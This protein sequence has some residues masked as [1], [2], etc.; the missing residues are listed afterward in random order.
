MN[1][2]IIRITTPKSKLVVKTKK[3]FKKFIESLSDSEVQ[4]EEILSD[5][6]KVI[7]YSF[8]IETTCARE[9]VLEFIC[10]Y[11]TIYQK[12]Q[13]EQQRENYK[14]YYDLKVGMFNAGVNE[15]HSFGEQR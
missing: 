4:S 10:M 14:N 2:F 9:Q 7:G 6:L 15:S 12:V 13:F 1:K 8:N 11:L 3:K 5:N